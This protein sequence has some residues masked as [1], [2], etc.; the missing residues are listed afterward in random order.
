MSGIQPSARSIAE[1]IA[2]AC[3]EV[4]GDD[5]LTLLF[6]GSAVKGGIIEGSSDVDFVL[7]VRREILT[8]SDQLPL[9]RATVFQ[10]RLATID[11][12]P[13]RY[14]QGYVCAWDRP[15]GA[16][17]IPDAYWVGYGSKNVPLATSR[18]L[19]DAATMA[20]S[21]LDAHG[22]PDRLSGALLKHGEYRL[23]R[24]VRMLC[25]DAWPTVAH[26]ACLAKNDGFAG[27]QRTKF[28]NVALLGDDPI[29][30]PSLRTW[31][32]TITQYYAMDETVD[33]ALAAI[34][35]GS[36]LLDAAAEWFQHYSSTPN[37]GT[38]N[39]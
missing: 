23:D 30:G 12:T 38:A 20:L 10:R 19:L 8:D 1:R 26:I 11:P 4:L 21:T 29:I 27:W 3:V 13:F 17:F 2:L 34:T 36:A 22:H 24:Q 39:A 5:L 37:P 35:A 15:P 31:V 25:T 28:E 14:L 16:G 32:S 18:Q 33:S 6:H 7:I 9:T